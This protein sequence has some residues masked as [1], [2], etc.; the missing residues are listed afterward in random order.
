MHL[1]DLASRA[2]NSQH[3]WIRRNNNK[4]SSRLDLILTNLPVTNLKYT[5]KTTI[6]DHA[7]VQA[8]F[9]QNRAQTNPTMK[10]HILGSEEFLFRYYDLL[11]TELRTCLTKSPTPTPQPPQP[12]SPPPREVVITPPSSPATSSLACSPPDH[13]PQSHPILDDVEEDVD[14]LRN[15][16]DTGLTAHNLTTGRTDLHFVNSLIKKIGTLHNEID[17]TSRLKKEENLINMSKRQYYL[18]KEIKKTS[19]PPEMQQQYQEE[20]NNLQRDLRM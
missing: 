9:G 2:R 4:I 5:I 16:M 12:N 15:P 17:K 1:V 3:T 8:T 10:D 14:R 6:F 13:Q 11:E 19:T 20:Y 7:W 18:H